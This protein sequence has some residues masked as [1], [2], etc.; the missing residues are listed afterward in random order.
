MKRLS[1][2]VLLCITLLLSSCSTFSSKY[3]I[4][5]VNTLTSLVVLKTQ[6]Q[7]A[8][9]IVQDNLYKFTDEEK[10]NLFSVQAN[11]AV[12]IEDLDKL[13][14]LNA[15]VTIS[16]IQFMWKLA[17]DSYVTARPVVVAHFN[18]F[19]PI[20]QNILRTFDSQATITNKNIEMLL[21]DPTTENL[22]QALTM[23]T[24]LAT[25]ATHI[26]AIL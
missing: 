3:T 6:Y 19:T 4:D 15:I 2:G 21:Q 23:V 9:K 11:V 25:I 22:N 18:E 8:L 1:V 16:E 14:R 26:V 24:T 7:Q 12:L 13:T 10:R 5:S 20:E 17:V